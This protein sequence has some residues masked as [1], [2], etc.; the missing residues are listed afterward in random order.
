MLCSSLD[1]A[2]N[3][4]G[5]YS[6]AGLMDLVIGMVLFFFPY[7]FDLQEIEAKLAAARGW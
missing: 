6:E 2:F 7:K 1:L 3:S 4:L 5:V